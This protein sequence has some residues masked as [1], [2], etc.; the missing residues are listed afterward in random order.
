MRWFLLICV[1]FLCSCGALQ[2]LPITVPATPVYVIAGRDG[3]VGY[4]HTAISLVNRVN[5]QI[6]GNRNLSTSYIESGTHTPSDVWIGFAG[7]TNEDK[8]I[9]SKIS[10]D[11]AHQT[12]YITCMEPR[13]IHRYQDSIIVLCQDRGF[14]TVAMRIRMSD[15]K[16]LAQRELT[17]HWGDMFFD[18]SFLIGDEVVVQGG[19]HTA[20]ADS[21]PE[22][23]VLDA[24]TLT[25]KRL[26]PNQALVGIAEALVHGDTVYILN[27]ISDYS[28]EAHLPFADIYTFHAGDAQF[29]PMPP[30]ARAPQQGVIVGNYLYTLHNT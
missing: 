12:D 22:L 29:M 21:P 26:I 14:V 8:Y 30:V 10:Y 23:Q 6:M 5:W 2:V 4:G 13:A 20:P 16:V 25:Q 9:V 17:T 18:N 27:T 15:G 3:A 19:S 28:A 1:F 7:D 11:L 24:T